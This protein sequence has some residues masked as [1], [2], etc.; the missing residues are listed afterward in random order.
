MLR[1]KL[2][3]QG[4]RYVRRMQA[5]E[6]YLPAEAEAEARAILTEVEFVRAPE[7]FHV[8]A[9]RPVY[10]FEQQAQDALAEA[11][12]RWLALPSCA[13]CGAPFEHGCNSGACSEACEVE[14]G[15]P[16]L[17]CGAYGGEHDPGCAVQGEAVAS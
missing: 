10:V 11:L 12:E 14:A 2:S 15:A 9:G 8:Q 4:A 3:E 17:V 6:V 13:V 16:C 7:T 1:A 5:R